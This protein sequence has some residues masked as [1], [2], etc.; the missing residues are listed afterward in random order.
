M[1]SPL[2]IRQ[3]TFKKS[4]RGYDVDEVK[5][6]L[7]SL[8]QVWEQ[9]QTDNKS[10]KMELQQTKDSLQSFKEMESILHKTLLQAE[11]STKAAIES[12]KRDAELKI[13][14]AEQNADQ[15]LQHA[16]LD[17]E[18]KQQETEQ[19]I[20]AMLTKA[21]DERSRIEQEINELIHRRNDILH[22]LDLFLKSQ[23]RRLDSFETSE[24]VHLQ[25]DE[26][27]RHRSSQSLPEP[28]PRRESPPPRPAPAA[29]ASQSEA[30]PD[31]SFFEDA[32]R[33]KQE[34]SNLINAIADEL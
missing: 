21:Y 20:A 6:F 18:M 27:H 23:L 10:L 12:A 11:Q 3:H 2:E 9:V 31:K 33:Q 15:I 13:Q 19:K 25:D 30:P 8:S 16:Q 34:A 26:E 24:V 4:L 14:E 7:N 5:A 29:P 32:L 22:Q 1:I 28:P 17:S